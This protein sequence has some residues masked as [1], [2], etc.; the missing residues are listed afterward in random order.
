MKQILYLA[1]GWTLYFF[2]HSAL[3]SDQ[4]KTWAGSTF[5]RYFRY[6][7]LAYTL[8][9]LA[10]MLALLFFNAAASKTYLCESK[11]WIRYASL[12]VATFGMFIIREA[13]KHYRLSGF[14]GFTH[15]T[16]EFQ[17]SGLLS[18]VRHPLYSG[19]ILMVVGFF[20]FVPTTATLTSSVCIFLYLPVGIYLE[21]KKLIRQ[22]GEA[23][24]EYR[25]QVPALIP[26]LFMISFS[27]FLF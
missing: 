22:F 1:L 4:V 10:G 13:F 8:V 23:Y 14:L 26:R 27:L 5:G 7:R 9:A 2:L 18:K 11:G 15:E 3:A 25:K 16:A 12:V 21:E 24:R 6:Y 20:M 19:T 17:Q